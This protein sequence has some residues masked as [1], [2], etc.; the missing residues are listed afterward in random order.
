MYERQDFEKALLMA[1]WEYRIH[2]DFLPV[3]RFA[4]VLHLT[5]PNMKHDLCSSNPC[6]QYQDCQ[7]LQNDKSKYICLCKSNFTGE[8]C[9]IADQQC[10]DGYCAIGSLCKPNY[11]GLLIGKELPYCICLFNWLGERC[12]IEHD[13]C[14][15]TPCQNNGTCYAASKPDTI[16]CSC[17]EEY[18]GNYC[19][20][21]KP[22]IKLFINES[23]S[24]VG[25]VIQ[26]FDIDFKSL[27]LILVQQ[28]V[29]R[30]LP[31][32]IE[33]RHRQKT[34]PE[35]ILAK[36]YSSQIEMSGELYLISTHVDVTS[37]DATT[38]V[39]EE[40]RCI[41]IRTLISSNDTQVISNYSPI[42][43]H[44][45]CQ[46]NT[47]LFCFRD[48]FYLCICDENHT[49]VECFRYDYKLDYCSYCL[50]GGRCITEDRLR[51]NNFICLCPPCYSGSKCQFNSNSF[52]FTLDQLFF[53]DLISSI[54]KKTTF[55]S[56]IIIPLL[57]FLLALPNNFFSIITFRRQNCLRN[58]I[59]QYL[60]YMSIINQLNLGVL[61]ARLIHLAVNITGM[62]SYPSMDQYLCKILSYLLTS[63]SRM[64]YWL[65]SLV[66]I[67]RV[68]MTLFLS[69]RWLKKPHIARRLIVLTLVGILISDIHEL[70]FV[71]SLLEINND[72]GGMCVIEFP[73]NNQSTWIL[74]HHIISIINSILPLLINIC[75]T[76][77]ISCVIMKKKINILVRN[78][79]M[80]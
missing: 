13:R 79:R 42:K 45:L 47:N 80:Y 37:I 29:Y 41:H 72:N 74:F 59:G 44:Y 73:I 43:Y 68:Y 16:S 62:H 36:I 39:I 14:N 52:G 54:H 1:V 57:L 19:E 69:G 46:N 65:S 28:R 55:R 27:N 8:N 71:K 17:T 10:L 35:I 51:S 23:I 40:N 26:Y 66:A 12:E 38:Q 3:F 64:V 78:T 61:A 50:A 9:S 6:N 48:D 31:P 34:A 7:Q 58:G 60:L 5:K 18:S 77:T 2:F 49:R 11:R 70:V 30:T 24:H 15:L 53:T 63:S 22:Q 4:K 25:A 21:T 67:E 56:L 75:C 33:Y 20:V 76:I 32:L